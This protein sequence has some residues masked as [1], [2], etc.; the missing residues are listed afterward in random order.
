MTEH[1]PRTQVATARSA[2]LLDGAVEHLTRVGIEDFTLAR[3]AA[4]LGTSSRML[5]YH[6][7]SRDE[8]LARV[9]RELRHRVTIDLRARR[10][11]T[12]SAAV[13]ATWDYYVARLPHMQLFHHLAARA[14]ENP[15]DFTAF[16]DTAVSEW[17][18]FFTEVAEREGYAEGEAHAAGRLAL[19]G[20]R[21]LIQDLLLTGDRN[22]LERSIDLFA[23]ML[24]ARAAATG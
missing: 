11:D 22:Q 8:L 17:E 13:R 16:T 15:T 10:L 12:L 2:A 1:D 7:G 23:E 20:F 19:A 24:D 9:Q 14:F 21:G 18:A 5:I 4:A 3:L 6:F